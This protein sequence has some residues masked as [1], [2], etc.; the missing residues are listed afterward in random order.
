MTQW[1]VKDLANLTKLS[2]QTLHYYDRIGL[3]QP[4][5]R[6][7]NGYRLYSEKDLLKL[8]QIIALKFFGF[9][10]AQIKTLLAGEADLVDHFTIQSQ[11]LEEKAK[12]LLDASQTL[13][14]I[15]AECS[16]HQSITWRTLINLIEVYQMSQ[17]LENKWVSKVLN[18]DE[19]KAYIRFEQD[20]KTKFT[21]DGKDAWEK[22]WCDIVNQVNA[23]VATDPAS[24]AGMQIGKSCMA[25]VNKLYGKEHVLL[26][27]AIWEKGFKSGHA[28]VSEH[29]LSPEAVAWL[30]RAMDAYYHRQIYSILNNVEQQP[31]DVI[32]RAWHDLLTEMYGDEEAPKNE[33]IQ[34]ALQD[35]KVS[36]AAK[37]WLK[38]V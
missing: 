34:K 8:Q 26:R 10:L 27:N 1:Y 21:Q 23:N 33:L 25:W 19:L 20:L 29:G 13:K 18:P 11:F 15:I 32:L 17:A 36:A 38:E 14:K 5:V 16:H 30:D 37:A 4:S 35:E 3:L 22:G 9:E 2:V 7:P 31:Q 24:A 12:T 28:D 6:L